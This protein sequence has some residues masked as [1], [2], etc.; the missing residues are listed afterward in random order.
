MSL[1]KIISYIIHPIIF[2]IVATICFFILIPEFLPRDLKLQIIMIVFISTYVIP[3]V[4]LLLLKILGNINSFHLSEI[5]ERKYPIFFFVVLNGL[6]AYRLYL[7]PKLELLS[8]FFLASAISLFIVYIFLFFKVKISLH[9]LALSIFTI[10]IGVISYHYKIRLIVLISFLLLLT[11]YIAMARLKLKA[12]TLYEVYL[13]YFIGIPVLI[14]SYLLY[15]V[16]L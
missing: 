11:G 15:F 2:G 10:F 6:L 3:I 7:I 12:H 1:E 8:L 16:I 9:T 14:L 4:F 5:K 13:G